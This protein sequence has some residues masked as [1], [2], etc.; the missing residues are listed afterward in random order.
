M[1]KRPAEL[2]VEEEEPH[3]PLGPAPVVQRPLHHLGFELSGAPN[4]QRCSQE[5][6]TKTPSESSSEGVFFGR[7]SAACMGSPVGG[8]TGVRC[9][10]R[11]VNG[12]LLRSK[13][14]TAFEFRPSVHHR[15]LARKTRRSLHS[16]R[17]GRL[18]WW[19][20]TMG[21]RRRKQP[22]PRIDL[23]TIPEHATGIR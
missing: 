6:K 16:R 10:R 19:E 21:H 5:Q 14:A 20:C 22:L 2:I 3:T 1:R 8:A 15:S 23:W 13:N 11:S 17:S 7:H 9:A 12:I 18:L 4:S